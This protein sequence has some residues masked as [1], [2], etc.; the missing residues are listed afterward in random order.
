M[1]SCTIS[2]NK[3]FLEVED[4]TSL[5]R[6]QYVT[7]L[8]TLQEFLNGIYVVLGRDI[9]NGT[10]HQIYADLVADNIKPSSTNTSTL[11]PHYT[12]N[13]LIPF[14]NT[15]REILNLWTNGYQL[16]HSCNFVIDKATEL[17]SENPAIAKQMQGE[18][19]AIRALIHHVL[20]NIFAQ[21]YNYSTEGNHPGVPYITSVEWSK[22]YNRNTV[23]EVYAGI[24]KDLEK[25]ISLFPSGTYNTLVMNPTAAKALL[26]RVYLYKEDWQKAKDIAIEIANA[27]PL[28]KADQYPSKLFTLQETEALFQLAPSHTSAIGGSYITAFQGTYFRSTAFLATIDIANLL[29]SNPNDSRSK[30]ISSGGI[31]KDSIRKYPINI[32]ANFGSGVNLARSYYQ[33][34]FRSSEM[35]LTVAEASAKAGDEKTAKTYLD[36]IRK[37]ANPTVVNSTATGTA[38]LDS[39]YLER[40]KELA[41]EGLRMFDL[42]RWKKGVNRTDAITGAPTTL[43][44]PSNKAIAPIPA[45]D[46]A[47]GITQ[48]IDY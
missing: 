43:S 42:L 32:V 2:C 10:T 12:W 9:Y 39:I 30:W 19:C 15:N 4:N 44:Y 11:I 6:Q 29:V 28:L 36:A 47:N 22:S 46:A 26:A 40:R 13:Q 27:V 21:P 14:N 5:I 48:N 17:S 33:T 25:A 31:G 1:Y 23:N 16:I 38:L 34:L 35:F 7:N 20:T 3:S 45:V 41:F 24:I 8:R 18:A 37:R